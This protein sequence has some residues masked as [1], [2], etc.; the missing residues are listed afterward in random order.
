MGLFLLIGVGYAAVKLNRLPL[1][2]TGVLTSLL[3]KVAM[4]ATV[5]T[6]LIRPFDTSFIHDA[7]LMIGIGAALFFLYAAVSFWLS[8][9]VF[10]VPQGRR[11][12]WMLCATFSNNG[13]MGFPVA[14]ALFGDEG[15]ALAVMLSIPFNLLMY[16][17]GAW[18]ASLDGQGQGGEKLSWRGILLNE[19]NVTL[20]V[21]LV[22]YALQIPVPQVIL[23]PLNHLS[24]ITT[25]LSMIIT[26]MILAGAPLASLFRDRDAITC[27]SARLVILPLL[28]CLLLLPVPLANPMVSRVILVVMAMPCASVTTAMAQRYRGSTELAARSGCLSSLL[29]IAT[30]PL[31]SLLL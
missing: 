16:S 25:P 29:C 18:Q 22:F 4:P 20:F 1:S 21:G 19:I 15:M 28:S 6:S 13:F 8:R 23:T 27:V 9:W 31:I 5:F 26:G 3:M 24:N 30:L 14:Y 11:G 10:R 2:S 7:F 12:T 17:M